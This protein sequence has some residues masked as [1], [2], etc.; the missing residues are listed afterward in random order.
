MQVKNFFSDILLEVGF[1][2]G[3]IIYLYDNNGHNLEF[4]YSLNDNDGK[5]DNKIYFYMMLIVLR[6]RQIKLR[7]QLEVLLISRGR[8]GKIFRKNKTDI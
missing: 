7:N 5:K 8:D 1:N 3:D 4:Y 6:E 2:E